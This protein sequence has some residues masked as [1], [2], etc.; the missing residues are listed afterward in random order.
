M[1]KLSPSEKKGLL[2]L[3]GILLIAFLIQS[4]QPYYVKRDL[5]D[6]SVQDSIFQSIIS[7]TTK[8]R[9][10]VVQTS[11]QKPEKETIKNA[12]I[13]IGSININT[14]SQQELEKLPRIGPAT[15]KNIIEYREANGAFKSLDELLE[16]KRVG[17]KTLELIKPFI[18]IK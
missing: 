7:D 12:A 17:P 11:Q 1:S 14:A 18:T 4:L 9:I 8:E 13:P 3:S 15:A 5:Y 16:V 6:Y 2:V 10:E